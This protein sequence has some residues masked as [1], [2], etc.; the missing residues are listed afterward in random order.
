[1]FDEV[2]CTRCVSFNV[3]CGGLCTN[4]KCPYFRG[5]KDLTG[6]VI[7]G[8]ECKITDIETGVFTTT[9][10]NEERKRRKEILGPVKTNGQG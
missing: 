8:A 5:V 7:V 2:P 1:M 6:A 9:I 3:F 4:R 10:T